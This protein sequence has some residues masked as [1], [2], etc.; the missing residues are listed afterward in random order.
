MLV[1]LFF[2]LFFY[3]FYDYYL[4]TCFSMAI[5]YFCD[6]NSAL[7]LSVQNIRIRKTPFLLWA[8][9]VTP[10]HNWIDKDEFTPWV[11]L[12]QCNFSSSDQLDISLV[13][14]TLSWDIERSNPISTS[15]HVL[16]CLL[17][18][19]QT[20]LQTTLKATLVRNENL[21]FIH[22]PNKVSQKASE[23]GDINQRISF[24]TKSLKFPFFHYVF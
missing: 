15:S 2:C 12:Y 14:C 20:P 11:I 7:S 10:C 13:Q 4:F 6:L 5:N 9:H 18:K 24:V 19:H 21:P 1:L 16:F 23:S 22:Q 8:G 3:S 17:Y